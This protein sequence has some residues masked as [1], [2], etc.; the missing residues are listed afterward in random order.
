MYTA[1]HFINIPK[2]QVTLGQCTS[3]NNREAW[4][5]HNWLINNITLTHLQDMN[6]GGSLLAIMELGLFAHADHKSIL[7]INRQGDTLSICC[8]TLTLTKSTLT[9]SAWEFPSYISKSDEDT[10]SANSENVKQ[11]ANS[12]TS[13]SEISRSERHH[14]IQVVTFTITRN[15]RGY[16]TCRWNEFNM[17]AANKTLIKWSTYKWVC[18]ENFMVWPE[19]HPESRTLLSWLLR[20]NQIR[21]F[22]SSICQSSTTT[23]EGFLERAALIHQPWVQSYNT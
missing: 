22:Y 8:S 20:M 3:V 7:Y 10:L 5:V 6:N 11:G 14:L 1:G 23:D 18:I 17:N 9:F 4:E 16:A 19:T 12:T 2:A 15:V 21:W 13:V